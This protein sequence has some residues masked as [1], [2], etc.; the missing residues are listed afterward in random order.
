MAVDIANAGANLASKPRLG[1][2]LTLIGVTFFASK[3]THRLIIFDV[4]G[5]IY[6]GNYIDDLRR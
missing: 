6:H 4:L 5:T 3:E 2:S 1:L